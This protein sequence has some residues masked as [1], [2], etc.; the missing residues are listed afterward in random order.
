MISKEVQSRAGECNYQ[1][2]SWVIRER[3]AKRPTLFDQLTKQLIINVRHECY[4]IWNRLKEH[5]YNRDRALV[6]Y[7]SVTSHWETMY[8]VLLRC[9][10][11]LNNS[12]NNFYVIKHYSGLTGWRCNKVPPHVGQSWYI[13]VGES[14]LRYLGVPQ[15]PWVSYKDWLNLFYQVILN[16]YL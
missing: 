10:R 4:A 16:S 15:C 13:G 1:L 14:R 7:R 3:V 5:L 8:N 11:N 2:S 9:K 6:I 12:D